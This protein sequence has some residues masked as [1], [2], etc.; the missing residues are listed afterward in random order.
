MTEQITDDPTTALDGNWYDPIA[1]G[2]EARVEALSKF[3]TADAFY[4]QHQELAN[5][6]WRDD[7]AGEDEKFRASLERF[8][9]P[10]ALA[11]SYREA[12]NTIRSGQLKAELP[13]NATE[14]DIKAYRESNGI[15][16]EPAAYLEN[17]P[18]GL[19]LGE[20]DKPIA[21]A[22]MSALHETNAPPAVAHA[23][24][25]R[26][27][28]FSEQQQDA[29]AEMD[30]EA[31]KLATDTLRTDWGNDYRANMNAVDTFLTSTFGEEAAELMK[32]GRFG[33]GTA[34]MNNPEIL[35]GIAAAQRKLDPLVPLVHTGPGDPMTSMNDEIKEIEKF[36][37]T[38]RAEYFK[39]ND[40][41]NRLRQLYEMRAKSQAA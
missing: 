31:S 3:E 41:Q 12:Q 19:V 33:D 6:N 40:K 22:F 10:Q 1:N 39:D 18:E 32:N 38:N 13:E 5:K 11:N 2:D 27:N 9:S 37:Q 16:L 4:E 17:L 24:I 34:F 26:Y 7:F 29:E 14:E 35:K 8:D 28:E 30:L 20:D 36:M 21:D 15:P 25:A 23:L